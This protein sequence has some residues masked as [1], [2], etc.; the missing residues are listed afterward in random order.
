MSDAQSAER[1]LYRAL[2]RTRLL[3][4]AF[5]FLPRDDVLNPFDRCGLR[6]DNFGP[7]DLLVLTAVYALVGRLPRADQS[8]CGDLLDCGY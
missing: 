3:A 4:T 7:A 8:G 5:Y 2:D 6:H 1:I